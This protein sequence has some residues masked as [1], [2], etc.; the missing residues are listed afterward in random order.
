[1]HKEQARCWQEGGAGKFG[2][3]GCYGNWEDSPGNGS[4]EFKSRP[5]GG[6]LVT[7]AAAA[8]LKAVL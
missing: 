1:M 2:I 7:R 3:Y 4:E 5:S 8:T 6:C